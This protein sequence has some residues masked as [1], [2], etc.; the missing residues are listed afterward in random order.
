MCADTLVT[1]QVA[2]LVFVFPKLCG[3]VS[4]ARSEGCVEN[5]EFETLLVQS[6]LP[7]LRL[8]LDMEPIHSV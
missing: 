3:V 8:H 6:M 2:A 4:S 5:V 1:N 7:C